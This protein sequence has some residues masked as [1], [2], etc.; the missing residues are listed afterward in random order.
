MFL[1]GSSIPSL[2]LG[3]PPELHGAFGIHLPILH[4]PT[5]AVVGAEALVTPET[6]MVLP[7]AMDPLLPRVAK[8]AEIATLQ[9]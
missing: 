5:L 7:T 8:P 9:L 6:D 3:S 2:S 1:S 4:V